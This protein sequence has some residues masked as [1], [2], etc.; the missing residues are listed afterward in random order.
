MVQ[1]LDV[2]PE[3]VNVSFMEIETAST[4]KLRVFER[5][6]GETLACG[7]G[8]CAAVVHG[9]RLGLLSTNVTVTLPG[10]KLEVTWEDEDAPVWLSG[11]AE[12][13]FEGKLTLQ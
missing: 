8:A 7:S 5:G 4:I 2:F 10:G 13:V 9:I 3:G 12:T 1:A 6:V 11:P